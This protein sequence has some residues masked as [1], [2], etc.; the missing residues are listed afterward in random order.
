MALG[1]TRAMSIDSS[2]CITTLRD[3]SQSLSVADFAKKHGRHFLIFNPH[4]HTLEPTPYNDRDA[5]KGTQKIPSVAE[6]LGSQF[7]EPET[8]RVYVLGHSTDEVKIGR[9]K[10][11]HVCIDDVSLSSKHAILNISES[12]EALLTDLGSK[13]GSRI[14]ATKLVFG[15]ET[16]IPFGKNITLGAVPVM[17]LRAEQFVDLVK[18]L[19]P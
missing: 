2:V 16:R 12:G 11:N 7:Q 15:K 6:I 8:I 19:T 4:D 3:D 9:A 5:Y 13:N 10:G 14:G 17:L 18:L 1:R